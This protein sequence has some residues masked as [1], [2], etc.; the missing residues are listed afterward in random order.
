MPE[1]YVGIDVSARHL[2]LALGPSAP[3]ERLA[4]LSGPL[5][6]LVAR[7]QAC[8]PRLIVVEATGRLEQP[9]VLALAEAEL[10]VVVVNP[11][12][13]RDFARATGELAKTDAIDARLLAL[14]GERLRPA[15]RALPGETTQQL[16]ALST[17]RRQ[18]LEM[19]TAEEQRLRRAPSRVQESLRAHIRYLT[20]QLADVDREMGRVLEASPLWKAKEDLL[21]GV[22][23]IGSTTARTLLAELPELGRLNR[24][25]IGKLAGVAPLAEDSG[26]RTGRRVIWGGR[27]PVR[28]A[29]YMATLSATRYNPVIRAFYA[30]LCARGKPKKVALVACMRKLLLILNRMLQ[31]GSLW[32]PPPAAEA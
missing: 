4:Y 22:P 13:V 23:G 3:V 10:P 20:A 9:L 26:T 27:A 6:A 5:S 31:T 7:L 2:D 24:A 21:R 8:A 1:L 16:D 17:R 30:Q 29:L 28:Q 14:F 32:R 19:R 12:Q 11:R 18:L 25:Q 15:V